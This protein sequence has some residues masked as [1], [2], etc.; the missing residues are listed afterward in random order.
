MSFIQLNRIESFSL[1]Y[2]GDIVCGGYVLYVFCWSTLYISLSIYALLRI[3]ILSTRF[4]F[5]L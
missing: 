3:S 5:N 1:T 2:G 4:Y